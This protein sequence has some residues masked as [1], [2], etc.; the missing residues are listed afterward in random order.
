MRHRK[1]IFSIDNTF[2]Q[3]FETTALFTNLELF[4]L[5][6]NLHHDCVP[7]T[8]QKKMLKSMKIKDKINFC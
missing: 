2:F 3:D 6:I 8:H 1:T 7:Q 5:K 4:G